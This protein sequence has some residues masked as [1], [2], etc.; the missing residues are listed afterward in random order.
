MGRHEPGCVGQ[1]DLPLYL[2]GSTPFSFSVAIPAS[3]TGRGEAA[4][5][6]GAGRAVPQRGAVA[7]WG[8]LLLPFPPLI[9]CPLRSPS[10]SERSWPLR[11]ARQVGSKNAAFFAGRVVKVVTKTAESR[12]VH[13][14]CLRADNL[15]QRYRDNQ[16]SP[17]PLSFLSCLPQSPYTSACCIATLFSLIRGIIAST[18]PAPKLVARA[19]LFCAAVSF[20]SRGLR[21]RSPL[22]PRLPCSLSMRKTSSTAT[23]AMPPP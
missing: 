17:C 2:S 13:E 6:A 20:P 9:D 15:E 3:N 5:A 11:L 21:S 7:L 16:A 4:K 19:S 10:H 18:L 22:V 23:P 8:E 12:L 14:L 1:G